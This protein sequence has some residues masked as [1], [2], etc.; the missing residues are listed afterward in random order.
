MKHIGVSEVSAAA[1]RR[2]HSVHPIAALQVE[3]SPVMLDIEFEKLNLFKTA[4]ELGIA[5]VAYSPLGRGLLT[6]SFR[7]AA[8]VP[9]GSSS[10]CPFPTFFPHPL[11]AIETDLS[12]DI[13]RTLCEVY[14]KVQPGQ[15]PQD[16]PARRRVQA[17]R[18]QA[19]CL[20]W[21]DC[22]GLA[23]CAGRQRLRHPRYK[24]G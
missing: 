3:Y 16:R 17:H 9:E 15:L 13:F 6:G 5:I 19:Q 4:K 24:E 22:I 14:P 1:L 8:D 10:T 2:A 12:F 11:H 20:L 23:T 18:C 21:P 7:N